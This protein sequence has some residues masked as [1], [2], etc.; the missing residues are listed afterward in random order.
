M[1][2]WVMNH[3]RSLPL[4]LFLSFWTLWAAAEPFDVRV[5]GNFERMSRTGDTRGVIKLREILRPPGS[6]GLGALDGLRGEILLWDGKL[7]VSRGHSPNGVIEA[8]VPE[9]KAVFFV[10]ARVKAWDE[11]TIPKDITQAEFESFVLQA[12]AH[13][14]LSP[15]RAFPFIVRGSFR[16]IL[17]HVV[18]GAAAKSD[19]GAHAGKIHSQGH[20]SNRVFD[21]ANVNGFL[22]GI[23]SGVALEGVISHPGER[24]HVHYADAGFS[25]SGH[26]D[27]YRVDRGAVLLLPRQ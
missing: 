3:F 7:L 4:V 21:Q 24:F 6:Y 23:Y 12:A 26:V 16:R 10:E 2:E 15:D 9:D 11:V 25:V 5:F 20:A 27:D 1:E 13:R 18:T 8:A 19:Q 22:L 14:G 17:W